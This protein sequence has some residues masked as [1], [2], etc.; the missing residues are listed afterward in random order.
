[1]NGGGGRL[2]RRQY[3]TGQRPHLQRLIYTL[4]G[5]PS[6]QNRTFAR[7]D[8]FFLVQCPWHKGSWSRSRGVISPPPPPNQVPWQWPTLRGSALLDPKH[9]ILPILKSP[10][11]PNKRFLVTQACSKICLMHGSL[12]WKHPLSCRMRKDLR[13]FKQL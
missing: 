8:A 2:T 13:L 11:C 6:R 7:F 5:V 4:T 3:R 12:G 1:M 9:S 10:S